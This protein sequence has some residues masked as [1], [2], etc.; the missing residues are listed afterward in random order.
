MN[1]ATIAAIKKRFPVT[2]IRKCA[3][4]IA[5]PREGGL[6]ATTGPPLCL[7]RRTRHCHGF[8]FPCCLPS[9]TIVHRASRVQ[10]GQYC[11]TL[12]KRPRICGGEQK[13][14]PESWS[15]GLFYSA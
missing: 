14:P 11:T 6:L 12:T 3:S 4:L 15:G 2:P 5:S 7:P 10:G 1:M 9:P 13:R 8:V